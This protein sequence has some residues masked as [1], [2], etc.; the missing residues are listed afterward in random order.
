MAKNFIDNP[1]L[2]KLM[3]LVVSEIS[4]KEDKMEE[5]GK[6]EVEEMW[7]QSNGSDE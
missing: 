6:S 1:G 3:Q 7:N 4:K 5:I 2:K